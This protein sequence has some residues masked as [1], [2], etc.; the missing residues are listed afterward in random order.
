M[1]SPRSKSYH[2]PRWPLAKSTTN[3]A[4]WLVVGISL[5]I[6]PF[7]LGKWLGAV[8]LLYSVIRWH[9]FLRP[10]WGHVILV[11]TEKLTVGK[12][13]YEWD[14]FCQMQIERSGQS[15][16]IRLTG[17]DKKHSL[18]IEDDLLDFDELSRDCFFY[19][20]RKVENLTSGKSTPVFQENRQITCE[21]RLKPNARQ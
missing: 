19:V 16:K 2:Y 11:D 21:P 14:N 7:S 18:V 4:I 12:K 6:S 8:P 5:F 3:C 9:F 10:Q 15:R 1:S 20:N 13:S 17:Q